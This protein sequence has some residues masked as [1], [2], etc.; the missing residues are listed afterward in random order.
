[1]VMAALVM[2]SRMYLG[3]HSADQIVFGG[4]LGLALLVI[5]KYKL[6]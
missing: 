3:A 6:R 1:M 2:L 4:L 5:Y